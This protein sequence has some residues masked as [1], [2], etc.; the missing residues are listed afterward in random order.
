MNTWKT[1]SFKKLNN[2]DF[3]SGPVVKTPLPMQVAWVQSLV[4]K[5]SHM[6]WMWPKKKKKKTKLFTWS[7]ILVDGIDRVRTQSLNKQT[8]LLI[9]PYL[10]SAVPLVPSIVTEPWLPHHHQLTVYFFLGEKKS[11]TL[12]FCIT[13]RDVSWISWCVHKVTFSQGLISNWI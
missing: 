1:R 3:P 9:L 6:L 11:Y 5:Q 7:H 12:F 8:R 2:W 13:F 10:S 4:G